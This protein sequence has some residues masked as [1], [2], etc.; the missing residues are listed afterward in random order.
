MRRLNI[1]LTEEQYEALRV[2]AFR[3]RRSLADVIREAIE[4]YLAAKEERRES[5]KDG[6]YP[7][8]C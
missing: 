8:N 1:Q 5:V 3:E 6:N 2:L 7:G 4:G